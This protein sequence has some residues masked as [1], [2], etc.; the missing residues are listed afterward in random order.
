MLVLSNIV[1]V[2]SER[3]AIAKEGAHIVL[4]MTAATILMWCASAVVNFKILLWGA[5]LLTIVTGGISF[6][7]RNPR[8]AAR[9]LTDL[10]IIS[11]ADGKIV[12]IVPVT[13][14]EFL[15]KEALR[16]SIF[17]SLLDVH[18]NWIPVSGVVRYKKNSDGKFLPAFLDNASNSNKCVSIGIECDDGFRMTLVQITG[19]VARRIK[20]HPELGQRV[21]RGTRYGMIYLGSRV[22]IFVPRETSLVV[23]EGDRVYG[24]I[25]VI[26]QKHNS[27]AK[28]KAACS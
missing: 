23:R 5:V 6:L 14:S 26:G 24:G 9:D 8:R 1:S 11:P 10:D 18:A 13:E 21:D 16:I 20:C 7:F 2:I 22:D 17:L 15:K 27:H 4:L 3:C 28:N 12:S 25:T 19:F